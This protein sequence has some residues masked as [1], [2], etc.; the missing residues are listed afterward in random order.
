MASADTDEAMISEAKK[1]YKVKC[2]S[3]TQLKNLAVLFLTDEGKYK[4]FD[5]S[6][7]AVYDVEAF[8]S[9]QNEL[10]DEYYASRFKAML[11]N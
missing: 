1:S 8:A 7:K 5:A 3:T 2:Y 4:F 10:K 11:R 6:Y 9:L